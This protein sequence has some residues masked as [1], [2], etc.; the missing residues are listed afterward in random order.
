MTQ[1]ILDSNWMIEIDGYGNHIP[2]RWK[3]VRNCTF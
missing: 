3:E 2:N 1:I